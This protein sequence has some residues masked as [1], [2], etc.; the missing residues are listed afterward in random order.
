MVPDSDLE[1]TKRGGTVC[2]HRMPIGTAVACQTEECNCD[3][4]LQTSESLG[5]LANAVIGDGRVGTEGVAGA[6]HCLA[7][8][9]FA[10]KA[11][12]TPHFCPTVCAL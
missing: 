7:H 3:P 8:A 10:L 11:T 2:D 4:R 1:E 12:G 6:C 9:Y 5:T